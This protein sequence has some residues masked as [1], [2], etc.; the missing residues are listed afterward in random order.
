MYSGA[1]TVVLDDPFSALDGKTARGV[2]E[3]VFCSK[4]VQDRTVV[5]VTELP[6]ILPQAD[7]VITLKDG[8]IGSLEQNVGVARTAKVLTSDGGSEQ[9]SESGSQND[10]FDLMADAGTDGPGNAKASGSDEM[11]ATGI[12]GRLK[13]KQLGMSTCAAANSWQS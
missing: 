5:L 7:L 6:W 13:G 2:W 11:E 10:G 1:S 12:T 8:T 4:L 3:G 9:P